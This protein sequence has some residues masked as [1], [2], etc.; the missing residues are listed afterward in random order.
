MPP[1]TEASD[2]ATAHTAW[3]RWVTRFEQYLAIADTEEEKR[4]RAL[5][6][7]L[8]GE[9]VADIFVTLPNTGDNYRTAITKLTEQ[10][11]SQKNLLHETYMFHQAKQEANKPLAQFHVRLQTL[12]NRCEFGNRKHF[13]ILLQ[14]VINGSSSSLRK[15]ALQDPKCKLQD[16]LLEGQRDDA[17][18]QQA[19]IIE[20]SS[21]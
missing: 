1:F 3:K 11:E 13:E 12:A 21:S 2:P 18:T 7:Y 10:F 14:F 5:L 19:S 6:I 15:K 17:S 16:I 4:K 8:A 20:S 9:T